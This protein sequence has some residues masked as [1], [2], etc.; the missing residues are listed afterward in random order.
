MNTNINDTNTIVGD[1]DESLKLVHNDL[2][3]KITN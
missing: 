2:L 1:D 3:R